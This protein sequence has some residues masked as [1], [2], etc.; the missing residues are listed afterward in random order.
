M[1]VWTI[2][3]STQALED[4]IR[5]LE[6]HGIAALA[7]VR[8]F[9]VS[10]RHPH[11]AAAPLS[12]SLPARAIEYH[13]LTDLGGRREPVPGS[14]NT[15]WREPA[16]RGYADYMETAEFGAA[17]DRLTKLAV[18]KRTA[19]MCAEADWRSCHRS[20]ISDY[21]KARGDVVMH[22]SATGATEHPF[23][24]AARIVDGRLSYA[25]DNLLF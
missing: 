1:T 4:F 13:P 18:Q 25:D 12:S 10:R 8:R 2:G 5:L 14:H 6:E 22:I 16:F 23:T 24:R 15:A 9:P 3:H 21:L 19:I 11:F 20:L 7:D 17:I